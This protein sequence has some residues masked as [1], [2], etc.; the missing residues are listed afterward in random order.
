MGCNGQAE[1]SDGSL[2]FHMPKQPVVVAVIDNE[3]SLLRAIGRLLSASGYRVEQFASGEE[4]LNAKSTASIAIIDIDLG[5]ISGLDLGRALS[6]SDPA[7]PI[8]FMTG[9]DDTAVLKDAAD[10]GCVA[11]LEKPF[12]ESDLLDALEMAATWRPGLT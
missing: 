12:E 8:I 7:Y 5:G 9:S 2:S 3:P 10:L 4:F 1:L 11:L 6:A